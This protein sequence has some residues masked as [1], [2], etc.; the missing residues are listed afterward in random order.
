MLR[1]YHWYWD[2]YNVPI[3]ILACMIVVPQSICQYVLI[4]F[5]INICRPNRGTSFSNRYVQSLTKYLHK[6]VRMVLEKAF[7]PGRNDSEEDPKTVFYGYQVTNYFVYAFAP[8]IL[9]MFLV[10]VIIF[11]DKFLFEVSYGCPYNT[12]I[13]N[14]NCYNSTSGVPINCSNSEELRH[15]QLIECYRLIFDWRSAAGA[16]GGI[17]VLLSFGITF[18]P[19]MILKIKVGAIGNIWKICVYFLLISLIVLIG[20]VGFVVYFS[21]VVDKNPS[22]GAISSAIGVYLISITVLALSIGEFPKID[23][24]NAEV[25]VNPNGNANS[26]NE[27]TPLFTQ[28]PT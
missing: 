23:G 24:P 21:V 27:S 1:S 5:F 7:K 14:L 26:A 3:I 16:T 2:L 8:I 20:F 11:W 4:M 12:N 9:E 19:R 15:D 10:L 6:L 25:R 17:Y 22:S 18:I 13:P 28:H